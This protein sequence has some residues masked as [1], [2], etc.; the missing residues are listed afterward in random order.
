MT[1]PILVMAGGTGGHVYPALAVAGAI[2]RRAQ[3]VVWLGT[4]RGLEARVVP[5]AGID[6]EWI[7]VHGLRGKGAL[8]L[9]LAPVRLSYALA[10]SIRIV[11]PPPTGGRAWHG[12]FCQRTGRRGCLAAAATARDTRTECRCRND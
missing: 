11:A 12:R 3:R 9:L 2:Q 5:A 4:R 1:R 8:T 10:Q 6:I 7:S